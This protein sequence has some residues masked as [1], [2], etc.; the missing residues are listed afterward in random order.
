MNHG[1]RSYTTAV[2]S[3]IPITV[4]KPLTV[5]A[6]PPGGTNGNGD[7]EPRNDFIARLGWQSFVPGARKSCLRCLVACTLPHECKRSCAMIGYDVIS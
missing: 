3:R 2:L 5:E 6:A 7:A 4:I 1:H